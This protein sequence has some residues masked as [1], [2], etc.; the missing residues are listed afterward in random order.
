MRDKDND[1]VIVNPKISIKTRKCIFANAYVHIHGTHMYIHILT[2]Y[3]T[4]NIL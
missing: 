4:G 2:K 3:K 1:V